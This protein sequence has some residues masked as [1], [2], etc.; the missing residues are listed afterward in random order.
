M[1]SDTAH[2]VSLGW[3]SVS[4]EWWRA[5]NGGPDWAIGGELVYGDWVGEYSDVEI[6]GALNIPFRWHMSNS[7]QADFAFQ[8]KPGFLIANI[9]AGP[10][11]L[12]AAAIRVD[13]GLLVSV[14][15]NQQLNLITGATVPFS[16]F[17]VENADPFAIIPILLRAGAEIDTQRDIV[18]HV[19]FDF[20]PVIA[21]GNGN[22]DVDF[23]FRAWIGTTFW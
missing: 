17:F 10:T 15:I 22:S 3:P 1:S 21:V 16:L 19:L 5:G 13:P 6:G 8:L 11:D 14:D 7:G 9:E 18:P 12:F 20:G 23:G 4:Y 2:H